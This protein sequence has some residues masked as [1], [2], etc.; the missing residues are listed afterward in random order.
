MVSAER[1]FGNS[2]FICAHRSYFYQKLTDGNDSTQSKSDL[3]L[4]NKSNTFTLLY[5]SS[6]RWF[7][8]RNFDY[9]SSYMILANDQSCVVVLSSFSY[10]PTMLENFPR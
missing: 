7:T 5:K 10:Q 9:L 8:P 3:C 1:I 4:R 6:F 2:V